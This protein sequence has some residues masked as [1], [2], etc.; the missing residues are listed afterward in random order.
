MIFVI[1]FLII[2]NSKNLDHG[3]ISAFLL[4]TTSMTSVVKKKE[5]EW[6]VVN[7][8]DQKP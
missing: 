8:Y 6:I 3:F 7:K 5:I 2:F 4:K 1:K